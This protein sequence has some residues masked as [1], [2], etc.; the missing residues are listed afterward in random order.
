MPFPSSFTV[1]TGCVIV[2]FIVPQ[3]LKAVPPEHYTAPPAIKSPPTTWPPGKATT[4]VPTFINRLPELLAR[5]APALTLSPP[6]SAL[7]SFTVF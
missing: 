3:C 5:S 6:L 1:L 4:P 7:N 2:F